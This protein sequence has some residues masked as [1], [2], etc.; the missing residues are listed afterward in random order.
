LMKKRSQRK[1]NKGSQK[2][3]SLIQDQGKEDVQENEVLQVSADIDKNKEGLK[4]LIKHSVDIIY[5]DFET[6][7]GMK[8]MV[9][10]VE[11]MV[12]KEMLDRDIIG[13]FLAECKAAGIKARELDAQRVK[14]IIHASNVDE[15][16]DLGKAADKMLDKNIVFFVNGIETS[17]IIPAPTQEKRAIEEPMSEV[18]ARGPREGFMEVLSTNRMM[19]RKIIK[20]RNLVFEDLVMGRQTSTAVNIAYIDG[21]ANPDIL[22]ELKKR[23]SKIDMGSILDTGYI[24]GLIKDAPWSPYNTVGYTERPDVVAGKLLEG[25]IAVLCDGSPTVLTIPYLFLENF[26][27]SEDYY[28]HFMSAS[29][30]RTLRY[31]AF[32][33]TLLTPGLY[34][35]LTTHHQAM[36]PTKLLLS[37]IAARSGVPFPTILEVMGMV[38]VFTMLKETGV[39]MPR[40]IGQTVSI[41]GA[42]V[43]GQAVVQA[44]FIS[45]PVVIVVAITGISSFFFYRLNTAVIFSRFMMTLL[46]ALLGLYGLIFGIIILS[47]YLMSLRSFGIPYLGYIGSMSKYRIKDTIIRA[48]WWMMDYRPSAIAYKNL[49]RRRDV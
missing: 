34:V 8:A 29:M 5:Y 12:F 21:I 23:L 43:L 31:F 11:G 26:Q 9:A 4:S 28:N 2:I 45:A 32:L 25:R 10:Y 7:S 15:C 16:R 6:F 22:E 41:V 3:A 49:R 33:V 20:N 17:F 48:P 39:R 24:E 42:L 14:S 1:K 44:H 30:W 38:A 36:I 13:Q 19:I 35:A 46:S 37:F 27:S 40:T 18:V 47:L